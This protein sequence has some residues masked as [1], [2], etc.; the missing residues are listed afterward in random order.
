MSTSTRNRICVV[1][2]ERVLALLMR[3]TSRMIT[4][5][6]TEIKTREQPEQGI[7]DMTKEIIHSILDNYHASVVDLTLDQYFDKND[8]ITDDILCNAEMLPSIMCNMIEHPKSYVTKEMNM[9]D[10]IENY[11]DEYHSTLYN[12][13]DALRG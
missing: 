4:N 2:R 8:N 12:D 3:H 11:L 7:C 10:V 5:V 1:N 9:Y 6:L 13:I